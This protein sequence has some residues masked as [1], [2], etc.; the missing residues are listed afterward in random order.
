MSY[1][2]NPPHDYA[3]EAANKARAS[4]EALEILDLPMDDYTIIWRSEEKHRNSQYRAYVQKK[5]GTV[6]Q[7]TSIIVLGFH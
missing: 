5:R 2:Y 6:M 4:K 3:A 7:E 1:G